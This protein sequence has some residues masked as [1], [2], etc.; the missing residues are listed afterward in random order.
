MNKLIRACFL[1]LGL[2][3]AANLANAQSSGTISGTVTDSTG[4][5]IANASI[6]AHNVATGVDTTHTTNG[7]GLYVFILPAGEYRIQGNASG[8]QSIVHQ[9][10]T[11]DALAT[12]SLDLQLQVGAS[13]SE[14][15]VTASAASEGIQTDN[16]TL[17]TTMRNEVYSALPLAMSQGV[18]RDPTSFIGLA[19]G[20]AAVVLQSAGPSYTSFNGGV[21]EV[22][23]LY[24]EGLPISFP[25]QQGDTRPIA[26]AVSVDAV[27]QF[28]VEINGEKAEYQGQGFHNY[29][30]KSGADQFHGG[31]FEFFRNT[32]LDSRNY[33]TDFVPND[34][35]NEYGGNLSGP[36]LR[37]KLFFFANYDAYKFNTSTAPTLLSV[38]S[39]AERAGDFS[40]LPTPIYD[41]LTQVC[42]G[43][44]CTK[45]QF[46]GNIIPA[47]RLSGVSQSFASYLPAPTQPGFVNNYLNPLSRSITN[48]NVT[49]RVDYNIS[50][51]HQ[52]YGVFAYGTWRTDYTGNITPTGTALPL[53]YTQ[54]PGI[55][56]E[57][58][59]IAQ[60][61]DTYTI[62]PSLLNNFGIGG[63]RISIP[64]LPVTA[65]GNY[66]QKAGLTGLPGTGQAA[67]GFP[68]INF[69]GSNVPNNWSGTGP[70]NEWENA[71]VAQDSL[72]WVHGNH[73]FKFGGTYQLTQD[74]RAS[75]TSGT[76][77]TFSFSNAQTAGF[78]PTG[79]LLSTTGNAYASYLLGAPASASIVNNTVVE[80]GS[81]FSNF[82]L[83]AQ[84]DWKVTPKL[85]LNL[86][87]RWDV[88]RPFSE[89]HNRYSFMDETLP[90][91]AANN[92]PGAL[93]YGKQLVN[94]HWKNFQPR[95]G[96]AY[97]LDDKTVVR[98]GFVMAD[99]LGTLGLGGN[100]P[101]GPG[102]TGYNAPS[103]IS[104]AVTG[105]PAF[106]WDQGVQVPQTPLPLLSP[107]FGAG[108]STINPTGAV[109]PSVVRPDLSGRSPYYM[110]WSFGFQRQLPASL[111]LGV[112]YSASV[113]HFLPRAGALGKY[114]NS[115]PLKYLALGSLLNAQA[116][117]SNVA[118]AQAKF[119]EIAVPFSNFQGTIATMLAPFPQYRGGS[120]GGITCYS[121]NVG[122]S[123][124]NSLQ[125][126]VN[127]RF[128]N[129]LTTQF[130][131]T[132]SKEIDDLTGSTHL[133]DSAIGGTRNP[134]D[135]RADRARGL[136]DHRHN[137]HW[138]GVY[139]LPFGKGHIGGGNSFVS[140]I[141]G[142]W[143]VSGIYSMV[144]GAPLSVTG[145]GCT[146]PGIVSTC[147]ASY[148]PS[149]TGNVHAAP[150]GSGDARTMVYLNKAAFK[151]PAPY[152]FGDTPRTAPYGLT[153]PTFWEIDS[154]L[155]K[156][157]AI[158]ERV[159][160]N[161]AADF[162]NL[163]NNVIF[164]EPATNIDSANFG[165]ISTTQNQARH[166]QLSARLTF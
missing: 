145:S 107:G 81:R 97:T 7:A 106:Y 5:I 2:F 67:T 52:L 87:L 136:I 39:L 12:V 159:N 49:A 28:Q 61:H 83:F 44:V 74:N 94:T 38:P 40:A 142:G 92:I 23:G 86:G 3:V 101:T 41:P 121:C 166:I 148:N 104:S 60:L 125:V 102:Q 84:D 35:Q 65:A 118:A 162:F 153:S 77:A 30:V 90:N 14:V 157:V 33:F 139:Q 143:S 24:F 1:L 163:V 122:N 17:G 135:E 128:A 115:M 111:T 105:Q 152:T 8:F 91:P 160:F 99:T 88:Y 64:I 149:F 11:L 110:N 10:V 53:P 70:F 134:F 140:S 109:A 20:V 57:R 22:N 150:I 36:I 27:N 164:A 161:I 68:G 34:H 126:T 73:I 72:V 156:T 100:G 158:T 50:E 82:S 151:D 116:T 15:T 114:T 154:T 147:I 31:I 141:I 16:T 9:K 89:S 120:S 19:P 32:A 133:L 18:P 127:R 124:Y 123:T 75:P 112:T 13:N 137:L 80:M 71:Y 62:S 58:P 113:A 66:P 98:A 93:V 117:P 146:T 55:V 103:A 42:T 59:L 78:S 56:V 130:A 108:N 95:V 119:P 48:Q 21:Q 6:T 138:T 43:T 79:T 54:T 96:L 63:V 25:N 132:W 4:A 155:R 47:S 69:S 144:T 129:G 76:S 45:S 26:L 29:V 51:K 165:R 131:Y 46:P 85:T 37:G